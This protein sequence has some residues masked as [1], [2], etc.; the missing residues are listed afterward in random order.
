MKKTHVQQAVVVAGGLGTRLMSINGPKPKVL[1]E[2]NGKPLLEVQLT[3]LVSAG[4]SKVTYLLGSGGDQVI[5]FLKEKKKIFEN[6]LVIEWILE[7]EPLGTGGSILSALEY[8]DETFLVIYGDIY[9]NSNLA[10]ISE[11]FVDLE[12]DFACIVHPSSHIFDSDII[13][14]DDKHGIRRIN[15]K[16]RR[17]IHK[18]RN[19]ANSGVYFFRKNALVGEKIGACDLDKTILP[20]LVSR[21][22]TGVA[23]RHKGIIRDIGT[24]ER[25][26][27]IQD[28]ELPED[29]HVLDRPAL[30]LDRDGVINKFIGHVE[31]PSQIEINTSI[32]QLIS[33]FNQALYWVFVVTNQ[34]IIAH[35]KISMDKLNSIHEHIEMELSNF[36]SYIDEF[37]VCPHHPDKGYPGEIDSLKI[38]CECRKPKTGMIKTAMTKYNIDLRNSLM[39]GD[40]WRDE[41]FAQNARL[42]FVSLEES[43]QVSKKSNEILSQVIPILKWWN[44]Q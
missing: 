25:L 3:H 14:I 26:R 12:A 32:G 40:T 34:P 17:E 20:N 4:F 35:G 36:G 39:I 16:T 1:T 2:I 41:K 38:E 42:K 18:F 44:N 10:E 31:S 7:N 23:L 19:L 6:D 33:S 24:P 27:E 43:T 5:K 15:L 37:F 11:E 13:E 21:K 9:I 8:L 22:K 29:F 30:F 28:L